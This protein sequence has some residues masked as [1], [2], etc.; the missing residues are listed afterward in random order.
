MF[1]HMDMG[2][3]GTAGK[4]AL[5]VAMLQVIDE[6]AAIVKG[7]NWTQCINTRIRQ[8]FQDQK[9]QVQNLLSSSPLVMSSHPQKKING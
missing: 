9:Q 8:K 5:S 1:K 7:D 2:P 3:E 6:E 4:A